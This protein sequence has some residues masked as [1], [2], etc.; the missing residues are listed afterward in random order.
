MEAILTKLEEL[1]SNFQTSLIQ[2]ILRSPLYQETSMV[3]PELQNRYLNHM[4][5]L[6]SVRKDLTGYQP[7]NDA[8]KNKQGEALKL[9]N[10]VEREIIC[11]FGIGKSLAS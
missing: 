1:F 4:S 6:A 11:T 8:E 3:D 10:Q 7:E 2:E 9:L 5:Q